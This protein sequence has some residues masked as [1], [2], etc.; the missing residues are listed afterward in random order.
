MNDKLI[1]IDCEMTGLELGHDELVEIAAIVTDG[2]LKPLDSGISLVIKPSTAALAQMGDFVRKMHQDSGLL[3]EIPNGIDVAEAEAQVLEYLSQHFAAGENAPLAGNS[4][5]T[6]RAFINLQMPKLAQ[7]L[8]YRTV[9]VSTIKELAKRWFPKVPF[10]APEKHGNH[11]ALADILESIEELMF[12]RKVL[13]VED[14]SNS[15]KIKKIAA[16]ISGSLTKSS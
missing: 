1:W 14:V 5:G 4:V 11:R 10:Q 6:D 12:Y 16:D 9:D 13:F 3:P 15:T 7:A 8:H 2:E